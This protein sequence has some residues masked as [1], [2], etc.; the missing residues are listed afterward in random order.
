MWSSISIKV[1]YYY[2][3]VVSS[4]AFYPAM[5]GAFFLAFSALAILFDYSEEGKQVKSQW[6]WLRLEDPTTARSIISAIVTG[7]ISLTVFSFSMVMIV[8]NQA[9]SQLSNRVLDQLIGNRFQQVVLGIYIG[10]IVYA[11]FL[12]TM[13]R[14]I[15]SGVQIPALS[16]YLLIAVTVF[17]IFLFIYFI[18]YITQSVKYEVIIRRIHTD[19][20]EAL[21]RSCRLRQEAVP[22]TDPSWKGHPAFAAAP[23]VY[24]G[25]DKGALLRLCDEC[26][27]TLR[28]LHTPGTFILQGLPVLE[29]SRQLPEEVMGRILELVYLHEG[30]SIEWNFFYGFKQLKEVAIKALSPGINDPGTAVQSLR[31]VF[32]LLSYRACHFPDDSVR[33]EGMKVRIITRELTFDQIFTDTV[34]PVWDYGQGDRLIRHELHQM[35]MQLQAVAPTAAAGRLMRQT[36]RSIEEENSL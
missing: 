16:T 20:K 27:C 17:D 19:T 9:A 26:D 23:G 8:L 31:A 22:E 25:F 24:V 30:E 14:D 5:I 2:H 32:K 36:Q 10:T 6:K 15:D 34:L 21:V 3:K 12:L 7:V 4:I 18:H 33:N 29:A 28:M 35:L 11:L 1:Q 13:I